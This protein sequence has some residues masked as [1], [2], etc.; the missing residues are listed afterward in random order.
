MNFQLNDKVLNVLARL[1]VFWVLYACVALVHAASDTK[2]DMPADKPTTLTIRGQLFEALPCAS[3]YSTCD[4]VGQRTVA[5]GARSVYVT[6][7]LTGPIECSNSVFGDPVPGTIKNC[8]LSFAPVQGVAA[9]E[10]VPVQAPAAP[11]PVG[12]D[13]PVEAP[14]P[15]RAPAPTASENLSL[16]PALQVEFVDAQGVRQ[17]VKV[18]SGQTTI[19]GVAPFLVKFDAS[20]TRASAAFRA[21]SVIADSEAHAFLLTGYRLHYGIN[22]GTVWPFPQGSAHSRDE[23]T[24]PPLFSHVYQAPG[25]YPVRLRVRDGLGNEADVS[26]EVVVNSPPPPVLIRPSAGRWP[27]LVSGVRYGLEANGDYRSFGTLE[28]GGRQ[29][30][31]FEKVG[32]GADPIIATFSPDGRGK[33][34]ARRM[35][36]YR[37]AHIRLVNIDVGHF[38]VGQRGFDY[39]GVIGGV[40]RR[41]SD[42]GQG[43]LWHEGTDIVRSNVRYGRGLFLQDTEMRSTASGSGYIMFG[44]FNGLHARNTRFVHTENGSSTY[45]MLRV[46]GSN[47]T[48]RNNLWHSQVDGGPGNGT[49]ISMLAI[50]GT[51]AV[52]WRDDDLVGPASATSRGQAYGY[53]SE[54]QILHNNQLYTSDSFLTNGISSVGGGNPSGTRLVYPRLIGWEDN[55]FMPSGNVARTIQAGELYGQ[56]NFWRNNRKDGGRGAFIPATTAAPNRN[57][58]DQ[59]TFNGP[60][61]RESANSRPVPRRF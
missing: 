32:S 56:Y 7:T 50:D 46:Y 40:I 13:T 4:F 53:I 29:N 12:V 1:G 11:A 33:F 5:Y 60:V 35:T 14:A 25:T 10:D 15:T 8:F 47:F 17:S 48:F 52:G 59:T 51:G 49:L 42:G 20:G 27:N 54:K 44:T 39:V 30:I 43:F 24:G 38:M 55:V 36:E 31:V 22:L 6:K 9:T 26:L 37:A 23:D 28:T 58:G 57:V 18:V 3:E 61:L 34:S 16:S 45:A 21:Q 41:F 19:G 2:G